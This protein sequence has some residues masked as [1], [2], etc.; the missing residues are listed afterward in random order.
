MGLEEE[1]GRVKRQRVAPGSISGATPGVG[2][3]ERDPNL[4]KLEHDLFSKLAQIVKPVQQT[5]P[6]VKESTVKHVS[7]EDAIRELIELERHQQS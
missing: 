4:I 7:V 6:D 3:F 1:Y 2:S 5:L